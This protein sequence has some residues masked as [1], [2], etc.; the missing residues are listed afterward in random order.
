[1]T[2]I[3]KDGQPD[4]RAKNGGHNKW[5]P[6]EREIGIIQGCAAAGTPIEDV[7]EVLGNIDRNTW[8][9]MLE[10]QPEI[11]ALYKNG[12]A[13]A[14]TRVGRTLYKR[15]TDEKNPDITAAIY[16]T[17]ARMGWRDRDKETTTN[18]ILVVNGSNYAEIRRAAEQYRQELAS[19]TVPTVD[20]EE[21]N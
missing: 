11:A 12:Q 10:R 6:T 18:N 5:I 8:I 4:G 20:A 14:H 7:C 1:M 21:E 15:A 3:R 2:R 17:K 16:Y 13:L 19:G 9:R